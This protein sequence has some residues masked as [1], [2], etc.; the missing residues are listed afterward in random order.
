VAHETRRWRESR[1]L[2]DAA[3]ERGGLDWDQP[4]TAAYTAPCPPEAAG[5]FA[6]AAARIRKFADIHRELAAAADR[7]EAKARA[8]DDAGRLVAARE[9]WFIAAMLWSCARW[10]IFEANARQEECT[11][12]INAAYGRFAALAPR[13]VERA[14]IPFDGGALPGYLH[15]PRAP[16]DGE[17]FPA[18]IYLPGMDNNKE[19]M[20]ALYGD[21]MLERGVAVLAVDGPGQAECVS[22]GIRVTA[23]NHAD[24]GR[25]I[26]D[27]LARR[28]AIDPERLALRGVSFGSFFV[29]QMAAALGAKLK[30]VVSAFVAHEPGLRTLFESA[31]PSFKMRFMMM[32]GYQD[33]AAFDEF[34]RGFDLRP[35]AA[36]LA[37][38]ILIQAGEDDELSPLAHTAA[39][40]ELIRAPKRLVVYEG[41]R[42]VLRGGGS[43]AAGESPDTMF[44]DWLA[45]RFADRPMASDR[46]FVT[47]AGG[48]HITPA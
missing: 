34:A 6:A 13:P 29:V 5:D 8:F 18:V 7:R 32:A 25:A 35:Y 17:R 10:P 30:G 9:S 4:R 39:L 14:E 23:T 22:R 15:L 44:A 27:W 33:E 36:R 16:R 42:H 26:H 40:F 19:Q 45:D 24:A 21:R 12:R 20:V 28:P 2:V 37:C 47:A 1:W 46:V 38:P 3:V 11:R 31:A 48:A 41:A 43:V